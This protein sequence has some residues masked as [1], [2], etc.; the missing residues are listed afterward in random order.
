[1]DR[2]IHPYGF[3]I[4]LDEFLGGDGFRNYRAYTHS[5][6]QILIA[7]LNGFID[8][9]NHW[10]AFDAEKKVTIRFVTGNK[11][12][13]KKDIPASCVQDYIDSGIAELA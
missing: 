10:I 8:I 4:K 13:E 7:E 2:V 11:K 1:M 5:S 12:G 3:G 6:K 9:L